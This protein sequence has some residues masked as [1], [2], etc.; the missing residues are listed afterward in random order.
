MRFS[1]RTLLGGLGTALA[2]PFV[3]AWLTRAGPTTPPKRFVIFWTPNGMH[4]AEWTPG[5]DFTFRRILE[6][7]L[8]FRDRIL[9]LKRLDWQ[10]Y[11]ADPSTPAND[12]PPP[13][14][15]CLC[16]TNVVDYTAGAAGVGDAW[17]GGPSIDQLI[18][19]RVGGDT[20]F[21]YLYATTE[22]GAARGRLSYRAV[23][24]NVPPIAEPEVVFDRMFAGLD[25]GSTEIAALHAQRRS[26]FDVNRAEVSAL[27]ARLAAE[28]RYKLDAHLTHLEA[29][30]ARIASER[31]MAACTTPAL[32]HDAD[33]DYLRRGRQHM[34]L[35]VT[36]LACDLTRVA[37][38]EWDGARTIHSWLGIDRPHH[39][40]SHYMAGLSTA[41]NDDR[42]IRIG[43]WYAE[44]LAYFLGRLDEVTEGDRTLLDN[45]VVLWTSEHK[46]SGGSHGRRDVPFLLAGSAGGYFR[47]GR[48]IDYAGRAHND[49]YVSICNAMGLTDVTTF[50][51]PDVCRG[52]LPDLT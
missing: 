37:F 42:L 8:P 28:E 14:S 31:A 20:P 34:D 23:R 19:Q 18:A 11:F 5:A 15:H 12:H 6:P 7:L 47:T 29:L 46:A 51:N 17:G 30:E 16:A 41:E 25:V 21:A 35:M 3:P 40:Y 45:T 50:G 4:D 32:L 22:S 52:P 10:S 36:A 13:L 24:E 26:V 38:L 43:T 48:M 49:L 39:D 44:Q 2:A 27:R 33:P 1:R 9:V